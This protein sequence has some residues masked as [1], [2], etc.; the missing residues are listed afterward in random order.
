[1]ETVNKGDWMQT[2]SGKEFWPLSPYLDQIMIEDIAHALSM[3]CRFGGH[4]KAFYSVAQ[5]SVIVSEQCYP[6][7]ALWGLLHDASEAYIGDV[8]RP[9]KLLPEFSF[10]LEIEDNLM[11]SICQRFKLESAMPKSVK[12]ADNRTLMTEKRD[13]LAHN[14][15]WNWSAEPYQNII[16]PLL[17]S[18]AKLLFLN[19][20]YSLI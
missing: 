6:E 8:I 16:V 3:Q 10:Y 2:H 20:F 19:R 9:L 15:E 11:Y 5:H 14:I 13:L 17:P 12:I 1:M 4:T 7:D 18:E